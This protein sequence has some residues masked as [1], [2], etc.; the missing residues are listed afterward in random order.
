[1]SR[2]YE[3]ILGIFLVLWGI[4]SIYSGIKGKSP[5]HVMMPSDTFLS[6]KIFGEKG[7]SILWNLFWG[8][9][10]IIFGVALL[11]GKF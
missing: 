2:T 5:T 8:I 1:M 4:Y 3:I 7:S 10:E 11:F 6:R 9:I